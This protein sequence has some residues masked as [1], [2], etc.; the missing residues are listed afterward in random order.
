[1]SLTK[2]QLARRK[3]RREFV[4]REIDE[5]LMRLCP[6]EG[7]DKPGAYSGPDIELVRDAIWV[8]LESWQYFNDELLYTK[9]DFYPSYEGQE[10][11]A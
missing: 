6:A 10:V 9:E 7:Q 8:V 4:D 5:L 2:K 1:M 3:D 11:A